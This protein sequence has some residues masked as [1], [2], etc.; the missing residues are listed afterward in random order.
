MKGGDNVA[1]ATSVPSAVREYVIC[2]GKIMFAFA[3]SLVLLNY[4]PGVLLLPCSILGLSV[5]FGILWGMTNIWISKND[6]LKVMASGSNMSPF[7]VK[8]AIESKR[9]TFPL[10]PRRVDGE[11]LN[12][13][14]DWLVEDGQLQCAGHERNRRYFKK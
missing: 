7:D 4:Y 12:V 10:S 1:T 14:L 11:Q 9:R 2:L 3:V 8:T 13:L 6:I 5:A